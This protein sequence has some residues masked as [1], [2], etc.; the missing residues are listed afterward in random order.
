[1][2][3]VL[4]L[5]FGLSVI[6]STAPAYLVKGIGVGFPLSVVL[7]Q[8]GPPTAVQVVEDEEDPFIGFLY[9]NGQD[10][11]DIT[12][13]DL[14]DNTVREV[15]VCGR[16]WST[17]LP[18]RYGM[19]MDLLRTVLG[20]P[21]DMQDQSDLKNGLIERVGHNKKALALVNRCIGD[22]A[23]EYMRQGLVVQYDKA[24][25]T[26]KSVRLFDPSYRLKLNTG[27]L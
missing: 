22:T 26:V 8:L 6:G 19:R 25:Q 12:I 20:L 1:M 15:E 7:E 23:V 3:L 13:S 21:D 2:L 10:S 14:P 11:L 16:S 18:A 9:F 17:D 24:T 4:G 5:V 27:D